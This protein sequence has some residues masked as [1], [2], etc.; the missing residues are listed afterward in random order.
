MADTTIASLTAH[1]S[2][3][4][5]D[6]IPITDV[7]NNVTKKITVANLIPSG[8]NGILFKALAADVTGSDVSTA[9]PWFPSTGSVAVAAA[10]SYFFEGLLYLTRAAGTT[11]HTTS[12]LFG[13]TATLTAILYEALAIT[14]DTGANSA[15]NGTIINTASATVVKAAST[16]ATEVIAIQVKGIIR[17]NAA[18]T[19]TPQFQYSAAPSGAPTVK[20]GSFFRLWPIGD[21]TVVTRGTWT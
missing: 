9:Q 3:I 14:G 18:G 12:L 8:I 15:V 20:S 4:S 6:V 16:S 13:G 21:N 11:S 1:T 5:T 2:V 19:L 17:I 10:T 7:T